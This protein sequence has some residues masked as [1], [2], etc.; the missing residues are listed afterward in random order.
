MK[1]IIWGQSSS[2][3]DFSDVDID[4]SKVVINMGPLLFV[5]DLVDL[6]RLCLGEKG[7]KGDVIK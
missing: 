6:R 2:K 1:Y 5:L 4:G 3:M 7:I